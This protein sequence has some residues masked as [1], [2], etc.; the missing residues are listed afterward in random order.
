LDNMTHGVAMF[1]ERMKL[2]A[3]NRQFEQMLDLPA[4][5]LATEPT[6][7]SL[8]RFLTQRGEYGVVDVEKHLARIVE[9]V[10]KHYDLER[11]RPD[12]TVPE[13]RHN[14]LPGGGFVA[15]YSDITERKRAERQIRENE[16]RMRS[17]L[18]G[19][20]IGAAISVEDGRLLFCNSEFARQNGISR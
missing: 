1:D 4:S 7:A 6:Y 13:I 11:T 15:I 2:A 9:N 17:I 10:G 8:I 19:S 20:P 16:Q 12:A 3:H 14:P 18:E 5:F